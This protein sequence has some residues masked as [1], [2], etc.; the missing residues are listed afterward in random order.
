MYLSAS[1]CI[2]CDLQKL[3]CGLNIVIHGHVLVNQ[4]PLCHH[5]GSTVSLLASPVM[6]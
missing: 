4:Q 5:R 3:P 2:V 1:R 6:N